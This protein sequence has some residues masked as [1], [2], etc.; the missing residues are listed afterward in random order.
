MGLSCSTANMAK[1]DLLLEEFIALCK[2][3][4]EN[5][6]FEVTKL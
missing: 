1:G 3:V 6:G 4:L 2:E 5:F